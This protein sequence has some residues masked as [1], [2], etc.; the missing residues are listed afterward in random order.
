MKQGCYPLC[1]QGNQGSERSPALPKA[2]VGGRTEPRAGGARLSLLHHPVFPVWLWGA[3]C[4]CFL[5]SSA[6]PVSFRVPVSMSLP[7]LPPVS[8]WEAFSWLC[9]ISVVPFCSFLACPCCLTVINALSWHSRTSGVPLHMR[10][11]FACL[12]L[13]Q[14]QLICLGSCLGTSKPKAG[15]TTCLLACG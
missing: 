3:S 12:L 7:C 15:S 4:N 13:T 6:R 5:C 10:S 11:G 14:G 8:L 9:R 1:R 2:T